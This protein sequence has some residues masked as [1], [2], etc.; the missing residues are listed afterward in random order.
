VISLDF[1]SVG[2]WARIGNGQ[3]RRGNPLLRI[4][5]SVGHHVDVEEKTLI[6][7]FILPDIEFCDMNSHLPVRT[8][9]GQAI[10]GFESD[11]NQEYSQE[12]I[13]EYS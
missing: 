7:S 1:P 6:Y 3:E 11:T 5:E 10:Q 2:K 13:L 8:W 9:A 4:C 12:L